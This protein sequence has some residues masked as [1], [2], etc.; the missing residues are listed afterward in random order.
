MINNKLGKK[1]SKLK[2]SVNLKKNI[3][4]LNIIND[5]TVIIIV[6][7]RCCDHKHQIVT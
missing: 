4:P 2:A 6:A 3:K 5:R 7:A 1:I